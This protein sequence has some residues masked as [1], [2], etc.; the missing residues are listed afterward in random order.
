MAKIEFELAK[1]LS[2]PLRTEPGITLRDVS[3][4][5]GK[6]SLLMLSDSYELI[7]E[8]IKNTEGLHYAGRGRSLEVFTQ[9]T[10]K[11][12]V[13]FGRD[14]SFNTEEALDIFEYLDEALSQS[15]YNVEA[16]STAPGSFTVYCSAET[17]DKDALFEHLSESLDKYNMGVI[18]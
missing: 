5:D 15:V 7:K 17:D 11:L 2:R 4:A 6:C 9:E 18:K 10:P 8:K 14:V 16:F 1:K 3:L 12:L 13:S